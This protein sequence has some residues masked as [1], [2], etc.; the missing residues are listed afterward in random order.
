[1]NYY[2][3]RLS[4]LR[5]TEESQAATRA[6]IVSL[7]ALYICH[8]ASF[9]EAQAYVLR[10]ANTAIIYSPLSLLWWLYIR[11]HPLLAEEAHWRI[12][13]GIFLDAAMIGLTISICDSQPS[14]LYLLY[15]LYLWIIMGNGMRFGRHPMSCATL[16]SFVSLSIVA[17]ISP[18]WPMTMS[19]TI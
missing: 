8:Y 15:L 5:R 3:M 11:L 18:H 6:I 14:V 10:I 16:A 19:A 17:M 4:L 1:M 7:I 13:A 12:Y 2:N 9:S